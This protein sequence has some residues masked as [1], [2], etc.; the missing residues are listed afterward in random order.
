MSEFKHLMCNMGIITC[1]DPAR[2]LKVNS[3]VFVKRFEISGAKCCTLG[4]ATLLTPT[5]FFATGSPVAKKVFLALGA[6]KTPEKYC[7]ALNQSI[8]LLDGSVSDADHIHVHTPV[9]Q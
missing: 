1:T 5:T 7:F 4:N 3:L 8:Q 6:G 9:P 2:V